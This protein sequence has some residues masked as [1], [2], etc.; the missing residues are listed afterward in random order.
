M[1]KLL[2]STAIML[3]LASAFACKK[4]TETKG[5]VCD[6]KDKT[7]PVA[8]TDLEG[9]VYYNDNIR[10]WC[11][12]VRPENEFEEIHLYVPCN[13]DD[14]SEKNSQKIL[15]SGTAFDVP[16]YFFE[17]APAGS[18]YLCIEL[19]LPEEE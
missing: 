1:T 6:C 3:I 4:N 7:N 19:I 18:K 9:T 12:S 2:K 10:K 5:S 13:I 8:V 11:L 17:K 15:F 16:V 14:L